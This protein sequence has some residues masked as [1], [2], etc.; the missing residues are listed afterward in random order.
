MKCLCGRELEEEVKGIVT[1]YKD[2]RILVNEVP[3]FICHFGHIKMTR[4]TR[5]SVRTLLEKAYE[6]GR[7]EIDFTA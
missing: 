7:T 2:K 6:E 5:K 3:Y 4:L 1:K